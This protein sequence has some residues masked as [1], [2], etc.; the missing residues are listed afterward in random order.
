M[1]L[2]RH[3]ACMMEVRNVYNISVQNP[4]GKRPHG[5]LKHRWDDNINHLKPSGNYMS[6]QL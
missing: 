3:A 1:R 5:T 2:A 6:H 4:E